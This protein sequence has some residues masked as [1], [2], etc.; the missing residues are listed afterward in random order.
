MLWNEGVPLTPLRDSYSGPS[1]I[2]RIGV[3]GRLRKSFSTLNMIRTYLCKH[4]EPTT[5]QNSRK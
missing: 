4:R 3:Y 1:Q 2:T 5:S